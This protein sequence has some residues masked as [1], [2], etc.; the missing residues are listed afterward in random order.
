M[1]LLFKIADSLNVSEKVFFE[2]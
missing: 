1:K 2:F